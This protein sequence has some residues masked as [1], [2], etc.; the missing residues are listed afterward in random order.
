MVPTK[1]RI[2]ISASVQHSDP[3]RALYNGRPLLYVEQS[4]STWLLEAGVLAY[5]I[6]FAPEEVSV[7]TSLEELVAG[8]DGV[9]LQGGVDVSPETYGEAEK[10]QQWPGDAVRDAYEIELVRACLALDRPL[11]GI[12]RGHQIL[13]VAR[14][15]TLFQDIP[16]QVDEP[17]EHVDRDI[18]EKNAHPVRLIEGTRLS[19]IYG[20]RTEGRVNSVHHQAIRELGDELVVEARAPDGMIEAVRLDSPNRYAAGLQW[21]PE[22]QSSDDDELLDRFAPLED[23]LQAVR[24]RL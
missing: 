1:L 5:V 10:A 23:F 4:M 15:G 2:G 21:H 24:D 14:G 7:E 18:Y 17:L 11:L 9:V 16:T 20:G 3:D 19:E 22:F 8:L 6:P 13:N 12:C